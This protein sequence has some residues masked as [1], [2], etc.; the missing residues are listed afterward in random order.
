[1]T[2]HLRLSQKY[3]ANQQPDDPGVCS[4]R[5]PGARDLVP[6][7]PPVTTASF[8]R[9]ATLRLVGRIVVEAVHFVLVGV[10]VAGIVA[11]FLW[12]FGP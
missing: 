12:A 9:R 2:F 11:A 3:A 1:M 5:S 8:R 10:G 7:R 4:C 6:R